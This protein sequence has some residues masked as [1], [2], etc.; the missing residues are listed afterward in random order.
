[1]NDIRRF[2]VFIGVFFFVACQ[3]EKVPEPFV[4]PQASVLERILAQGVLRVFTL[5]NT[6]DFYVYQGTTRGFHYELAQDFAD[7][8]GVKLQIVDVNLNLDTA[9]ARLQDG[10]YDLLAMGLTQTA[11]R[12]EEVEFCAPF[13]QTN[14]VLV[15]NRRHAVI[16]DLR[17][18]ANKEVYI[19]TAFSSYRELLQEVQ[20]SLQIRFDVIELDHYF[21]EDLVHLAETGLIDYT[22]IDENIAKVS[23]YSMPHIDYALRLRENVSISWAARQGEELLV[24]EVDCWL[25]AIR[26]DGKLKDMYNRYFEKVPVV[27]GNV[28]KYAFL[29][30]GKIS[31]YDHLIKKTAGLL[32]WDWRLV[33]AIIYCE[34]HFDPEAQSAFGAYGLMQVM[35]ETAEHFHVTDYFRPDSNIYVGVSYLHYLDRYLEEYVPVPEERIK[36]VLASYNAGPGHVL[37]AIRLAGKYGKNPQIWEGN[38][39][40]YLRHKNEARYYRDSLAKN[41]Y[42]NGPQ[43]YHYVQ[44]V[45]ETYNSYRNIK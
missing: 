8:L 35:P 3:K 12:K 7:Y 25:A 41:G 18:L 29:R 22:V 14:E 17:E 38:V 36:F 6:T 15:Q 10:K 39:D 42:C 44:R 28:S 24:E 26:K 30:K 32:G 21:N 19:P 4:L 37:D 27:P 2:V 20:D 33:A 16:H 9:I 34:S 40:F 5:Y 43:A 13:F 23:A 31:S 45:L 1:M 11:E